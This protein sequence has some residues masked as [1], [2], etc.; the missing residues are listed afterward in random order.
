M[1]SPA[2]GRGVSFE[3]SCSGPSVLAVG[4]NVVD[5]G[6]EREIAI[7]EPAGIVSGQFPSERC[8]S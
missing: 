3:A 6:D 8:D 7:G 4:G 2:C 1:S 5:H